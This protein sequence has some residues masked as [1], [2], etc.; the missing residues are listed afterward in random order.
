MPTFANDSGSVD[1]DLA[2]VSLAEGESIRAV[3]QHDLDEQSAFRPGLVVLTNT[4]LRF[5][6]AGQPLRPIPLRA[7]MELRRS[8]HH[9][10]CEIAVLVEQKPV[11]R[12]GFT[13]RAQASAAEF[14]DAFER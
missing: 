6:P 1:V 7:G 2:G 5:G 10:V 4:H 11:A 12:F 9:G 13:L 14:C 8:E 3:F